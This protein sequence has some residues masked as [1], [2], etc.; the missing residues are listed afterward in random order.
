MKKFSVIFV[1][2]L[3]VVNISALATLGYHRFV[4]SKVASPVCCQSG[5]EYLYQQLGLSSAQIEQ[6]KV[7]KA[8]FQ[9]QTVW[10]SQQLFLQRSE[11]LSL[12]KTSA[13][14]SQHISQLLHEIGKLQTE[15]QRQVIRTML[16][17]KAILT[18]KQQERFFSLIGQRLIYESRC[19]H[20]SG[21]NSLYDNCNLNHNQP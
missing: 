6:M 14:D 4:A 18:P 17:Q 21:L 5:E 3:G 16:K 19:Q 12:L 1:V 20:A 2:L 10:I 11:L 15:L 9:A 8:S 13:V 7:I